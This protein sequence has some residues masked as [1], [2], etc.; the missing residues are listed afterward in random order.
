MAEFKTNIYG[1]HA[2]QRSRKHQSYSCNDFKADLIVNLPFSTSVQQSDSQ[3]ALQGTVD[4]VELGSTV[5]QIQIL[6]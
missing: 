5:K 3:F 1:T 2:T 6:L 4:D